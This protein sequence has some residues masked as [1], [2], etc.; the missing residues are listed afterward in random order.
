MPGVERVPLAAP[1][2]PSSKVI[3]DM[4]DPETPVAAGGGG[5]GAV[6]GSWSL[7]LLLAVGLVA[8]LGLAGVLAFRFWPQRPPPP[9]VALEEDDEDVEKA[10]AV[11]NPGYVGID[12]CAE[13]HAKR[14]AKVKT[15]R[16]Y[17]A[18]RT[19]PAGVA[20][21]G[22]APGRGRCDT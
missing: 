13:C 22:F 17:L 6:E 12:A 7:R 5:G 8:L 4:P 11:V 20:A 14:A 21:P 9:K 3:I 2:R 16:H 18:C 15:S 10:L 19:A 1:S